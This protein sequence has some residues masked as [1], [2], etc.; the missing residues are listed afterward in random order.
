MSID[1]VGV[2]LEPEVSR[3]HTLGSQQLGLDAG[4]HQAVA[5]GLRIV[6]RVEGP[7]AHP[8]HCPSGL[9]ALVQP[10]LQPQH[11]QLGALRFGLLDLLEGAG[12]DK[13]DV[14]VRR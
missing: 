11:A 6:A 7:H 14:E 13:I 9:I 8:L 2:G 5:R 12:L 3:R 1:R 4:R 10:G